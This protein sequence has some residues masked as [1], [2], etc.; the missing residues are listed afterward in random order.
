MAKQIKAY[1]K[2][3]Y[4]FLKYLIQNFL[5]DH[6]LENAEALSFTTMLSLVPLTAISLYIAQ[7]FP[8]F[9]KVWEQIQ[10]FIFNSFVPSKGH[11]VL[12]Y[13]TQFAKQAGNLPVWGIVW[14]AV[15]AIVLMVNI[16]RAFNDIWKAKNKRRL[17]YGV[18][19]YWSVLTLAP[20]LLGIGFAS[21]SYVFSLP[22]VKGTFDQYI[23]MNIILTFLPFFFSLISFTGI[24]YLVPYTKIH[25]KHAF[26]GSL[27]AALLF[28]IAKYFFVFYVANFH[29]YEVIYSSLA[30]FP[31]FLMWL[32]LSWS[33]VLLGAELVHSLS[34]FKY[35]RFRKKDYR[36]VLAYRIVGHLWQAQKIGISLSFK[37]LIQLEKDYLLH[38]PEDVLEVLLEK[39]IIKKTEAKE[40][41]LTRNLNDMTIYD[42]FD[43][44]PWKLPKKSEILIPIKAN[45]ED[46]FKN[47][48][49]SLEDILSN[50]RLALKES[51]NKKLSDCY[52]SKQIF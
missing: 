26:L 6:C 23:G 11:E 52:L 18:A 22:F 48:N 7:G 13:L 50:G 17:V 27:V 42:F 19:I 28:E 44:L 31:I 49:K 41:I 14:L 33:I 39:R 2:E 15:V 38:D 40:Y 46:K 35:K 47:W 10:T 45:S 1:F 29:T 34:S 5:N 16:E 32:Y 9:E 51:L 24:Y 20:I 3:F 30:I 36:F 21:T 43:L 12:A 25:F 8:G 4:A 37:Q